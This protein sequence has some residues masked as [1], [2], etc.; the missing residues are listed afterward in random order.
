MRGV[1]ARVCAFAPACV[2]V[3]ALVCVRV[4]SGACISV[5]VFRCSVF[6]CVHFP[7]LFM[8][9]CVR[10]C[11]RRAC[12]CVRRACVC[13]V[14][15]CARAYVSGCASCM[16]MCVGCDGAHVC[17]DFHVRVCVC[18]WVCMR[19]RVCACVTVTAP[20]CPECPCGASWARSLDNSWAPSLFTWCLVFGDCEMRTVMQ[21][22]PGCSQDRT[23]DCTA[24]LACNKPEVHSGLE[25]QLSSVSSRGW[26]AWPGGSRHPGCGCPGR[27]RLLGC[28]A[29]SAD[30]A[31]YPS[32][33][34]GCGPGPASPAIPADSCPSVPS[35]QGLPGP[36]PSA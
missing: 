22:L 4:C 32:P 36:C 17:M 2:S 25:L 13:E 33:S 31:G 29:L 7:V 19:V 18:V 27:E 12:V 35:R 34:G 20:A 10:V 16:P 26:G 5:F 3:C 21:W 6:A 15:V 1:R 24:V 9:K 30:T 14:C 23:R 11:V 28:R 8:S